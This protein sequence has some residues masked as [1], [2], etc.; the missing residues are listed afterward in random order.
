[1]TLLRKGGLAGFDDRIV[2][3]RE[4]RATATGTGA[5][6]PCTLEPTALRDLTALASRVE[7]TAATTYEHPDDLV[8]VVQTPRGSSRLGDLDQPGRAGVVT[9]LFEEL[10]PTEAAKRSLCR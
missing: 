10:F 8:L 6:S 9:R 2:V 3:T 5:A 4:A 7:G 1:V